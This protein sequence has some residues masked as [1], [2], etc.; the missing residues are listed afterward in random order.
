MSHLPTIQQRDFNGLFIQFFYYGFIIL[1]VKENE[2]EKKT[3]IKDTIV[4]F[5]K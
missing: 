4:L 1:N 3:G 5:V 2:T